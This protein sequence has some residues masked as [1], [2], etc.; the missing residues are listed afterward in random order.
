MYVVA[1]RCHG[2]GDA[3]LEEVALEVDEVVTTNYLRGEMRSVHVSKDVEHS[4]RPRP[5]PFHRIRNLEK[6]DI[7]DCTVFPQI[8]M[9]NLVWKLVVLPLQGK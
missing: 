5:L 2:G 1:Q 9:N 6:T 7:H 3:L 8:G 4:W